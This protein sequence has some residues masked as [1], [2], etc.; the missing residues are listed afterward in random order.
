MKINLEI[1]KADTL[2]L[3]CI[4]LFQKDLVDIC[5]TYHQILHTDFMELSPISQ[6]SM[7]SLD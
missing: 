5:I 1:C 3:E 6:V 7:Q 4:H 2:R